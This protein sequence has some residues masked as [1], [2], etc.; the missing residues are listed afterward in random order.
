[1][2][3]FLTVDNIAVDNNCDNMLLLLFIDP[4]PG[5]IIISFNDVVSFDR[6]FYFYCS[7]IWGK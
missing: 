6:P 4:I 1:M 2:A 5:K 7:D 3:E